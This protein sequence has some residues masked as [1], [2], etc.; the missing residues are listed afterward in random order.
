MQGPGRLSGLCKASHHMAH[1]VVLPDTYIC[2][3]RDQ[4]AGMNSSALVTTSTLLSWAKPPANCTEAAHF[5]QPSSSRLT[6]LLP[7]CPRAGD[8]MQVC[9]ND[10]RKHRKAAVRALSSFMGLGDGAHVCPSAVP[11]RNPLLPFAV[12]TS[13]SS[14]PVSKAA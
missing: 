6:T 14:L 3:S 5:V 1:A 12:R 4:P 9:S 10:P 7:G 8:G 13:A 11:S 2:V